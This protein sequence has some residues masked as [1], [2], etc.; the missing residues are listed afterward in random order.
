MS[1]AELLEPT[2][3]P[4]TKNLTYRNVVGRNAGGSRT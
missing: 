3:D 2:I 1:N 4:N